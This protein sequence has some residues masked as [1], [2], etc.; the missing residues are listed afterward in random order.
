[1]QLNGFFR[2]IGIGTLDEDIRPIWEEGGMICPANGCHTFLRT[3]SLCRKHKAEVHEKMVTMYT[4]EAIQECRFTA[5]RRNQVVRHIRKI[6]LSKQPVVGSKLT[7]NRKYQDPGSG[8]L[9]LQSV[10]EA[11]SRYRT[12]LAERRRPEASSRATSTLECKGLG[13]HCRWAKL[14]R[15]DKRTLGIC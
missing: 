14:L 8:L 15:C 5:S 10:T 12:M 9:P 1:M 13:G 3:Y 11:R 7:R 2:H 4:C 6:H